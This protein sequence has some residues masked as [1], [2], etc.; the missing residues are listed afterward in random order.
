MSCYVV[1]PAHIHALVEAA[2]RPGAD[3][4]GP[5]SWYWGNPS[6]SRKAEWNEGDSIGK[7][8]L[9][10]NIKSVMHRYPDCT[11]DD[12][13]GPIPCPTVEAYKYE[14]PRISLGPVAILKA[15]DGYEYQSCEH[16]GWD[17][18]EAHAFCEALGSRMIKGLPGYDDAAWEITSAA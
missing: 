8:L 1:D 12:M 7:M 3:H 15:L 5:V 13:P 11:P 6:R 2:M 16:P 18:S 14:H 17:A 4:F 9:G 10:E